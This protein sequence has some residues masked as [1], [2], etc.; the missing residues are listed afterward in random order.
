MR[1][2]SLNLIIIVTLSKRSGG[3]SVWNI[4]LNRPDRQIIFG[5]VYDLSCM[6]CLYYPRSATVVYYFHAGKVLQL[7]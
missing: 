4:S 7:H 3:K 5:F 2:I 6:I 1:H